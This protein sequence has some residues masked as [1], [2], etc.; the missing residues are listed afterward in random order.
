MIKTYADKDTEKIAQGKRVRAWAG[1]VDRQIQRKLTFLNAAVELK[2][3]RS[4][5]G[6]ML[7][8]LQGDR[9]GQYSIRVNGQYRVCFRWE[10]G[11]AYD[12][13]VTDYH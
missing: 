10:N 7:E 3:L 13:E 1:P 6:N 4:P 9:Q 11:D 8:A 12:V 5:P 2:D